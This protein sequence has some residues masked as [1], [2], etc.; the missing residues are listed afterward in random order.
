M[1]LKMSILAMIWLIVH[2]MASLFSA[3]VHLTSEEMASFA[4]VKSELRSH[5]EYE[6][7]NTPFCT[8]YS[9]SIFRADIFLRDNVRKSIAHV[10]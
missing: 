2:L 10:V 3:N 7:K 9:F 6:T 8:E 4:Q 1:Q 5:I